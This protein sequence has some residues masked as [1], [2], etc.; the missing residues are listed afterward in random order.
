L[1]V[2]CVFYLKSS[3]GGGSAAYHELELVEHRQRAYGY[4][5]LEY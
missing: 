1:G 3:A 4:L 5:S 2:R